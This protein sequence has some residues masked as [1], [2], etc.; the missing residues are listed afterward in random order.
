MQFNPIK[1]VVIAAVILVVDYILR[2]SATLQRQRAGA[3]FALMAAMMFAV[4]LILDGTW[5]A[6]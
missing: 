3:R 2:R 5:P 1:A 4:I 6:D